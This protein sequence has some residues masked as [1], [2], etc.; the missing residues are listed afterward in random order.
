ME[1]IPIWLPVVFFLLALFYAMAGFAGGSSYLAVLA[2]VG[3]PY[4]VIPQTALACNVVV[5]SGG[6]WHFRRGGHL[7][8]GKFLPFMVLSI[9]M[10]YLGGRIVI[11]SDLDHGTEVT[12]NLPVGAQAAPLIVEAHA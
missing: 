7:D 5:S 6:V 11:D 3:L 1:S 8:V 9:P 12:L 2:V 4:Q 10:A